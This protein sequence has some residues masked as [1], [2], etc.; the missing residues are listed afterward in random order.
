SSKNILEINKDYTVSYNNTNLNA[1][2]MVMTFTFMGGYTGTLTKK[3]KIAPVTKPASADFDFNDKFDDEIAGVPF[4]KGGAVL[5]E[6]A[7]SSIKIRGIDAFIGDDYTVSYKNN[8]KPCNGTDKNAATVVITGKGNFKFIETC[9]FTILP[10]DMEDTAIDVQVPNMI[11]TGKTGGFNVIPIITDTRSGMPLEKKDYTVKYLYGESKT[12]Y[13]T[14]E[15]RGIQRKKGNPIDKNDVIIEDTKLCVRI[16][17]NGA[18]GFNGY[19][20]ESYTAVNYD[21]SRLKVKVDDSGK[22]YT[23]EPVTVSNEDIT[24]TVPAGQPDI[25]FE[26]L[27][28]TYK[29]NIKKGTASVTVKGTG[30]YGGVKTITFKIGQKRF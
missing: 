17:G 15:K 4:V 18:N 9:T 24:F 5:S 29:N 30:S 27:E 20:E 7:L 2:N 22:Y 14:K 19:R 25:E 28:H 3:F 16:T 23:G 13:N 11:S 10:Q 1:G 21:L 12:V 8:K 6:D 26:I